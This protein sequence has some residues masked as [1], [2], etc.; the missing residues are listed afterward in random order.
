M[1]NDKNLSASFISLFF[2]LVFLTFVSAV[3][4]SFFNSN[5]FF[6]SIDFWFLPYVF[7]FLHRSLNQ[8]AL[9]CIFGAFILSAFS[10]LP[11][12]QL[13][14]GTISSLIFIHIFKN[15]AFAKGNSYFSICTFFAI[16]VFYTTG[17]ILSHTFDPN[18]QGPWNI[19]SWLIASLTTPA[20]V[21]MTKPIMVFVDK[22]F[23]TS[24]P[25]GF[26]V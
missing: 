2:H 11:V 5:R 22:T 16:L 21:F 6:L 15:R 17:F 13:I 3:E 25:F 23:K 14:V 10:S 18:P 26:E 19:V 8:G 12:Y 24:Y 4:A 7:I 1:F 20:F 9:F